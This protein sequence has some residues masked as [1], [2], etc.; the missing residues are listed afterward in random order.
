MTS[1]LSISPPHFLS[2]RLLYVIYPI[3]S[4]LFWLIFLVLLGQR[5]G[6]CDACV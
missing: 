1:Y 3:M 5:E 4:T 6:G 2:L